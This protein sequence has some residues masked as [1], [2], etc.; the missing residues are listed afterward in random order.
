MSG[1]SVSPTESSILWTRSPKYPSSEGVGRLRCKPSGQAWES[2]RLRFASQQLW[3]GLRI[4]TADAVAQGRVSAANNSFGWAEDVKPSCCSQCRAEGMVKLRGPKCRCGRAE[5]V[6]GMLGDARPTCCSK[7]KADGM[8]DIKNRKCQ[9][10][11]AQP[12]FGFPNDARATCC[13]KC[14]QEGMVDIR[15]RKCECGAALPYFGY[16]SDARATCC[17]KCKHDGMVDVKNL[18]CN[19]GKARPSFG[20]T[21]DVRPTCCKQCMAAGMVNIRSPKCKVCKKQAHYPDEAGRPKQLCAVHSAEV[22]AHVLSS[23]RRSRMASECFDALEA[24]WG[25]KL[26]FRYRFDI[27]TGTWSGEEF[28]GLV[29]RRNLQPDAYDPEARKVVEFLGNYFHGFPPEHPQH[30]SF[31]CVGGRPAAELHAETMARL[32]L[33]L[34][35]GLEVVYMWEYD[36]VQWQREVAVGA[37]PSLAGQLIQHGAAADKN[38]VAADQTCW[39]TLAWRTQVPV[40]GCLCTWYC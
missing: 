18:R 35:E 29:P 10:G 31:V 26:P 4:Q 17:S 30:D 12:Y 37:A 21:D 22:G 36:F 40:A 25:H 39:R 24:E 15:N 2:C 20:F 11:K 38:V 32:D 9:C 14:K 28:A 3:Q 1:T 23:P 27:K 8:V 33:F 6:F 5:P 16:A 7:C 13:S 34:A 19:C